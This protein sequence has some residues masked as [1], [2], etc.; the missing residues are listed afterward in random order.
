MKQVTNEELAGMINE[1]F[2][3]VKKDIRAI[4]QDMAT[5]EDLRGVQN[6]VAD[7]KQDVGTIANHIGLIED[8]FAM[9]KEQRLKLRRSRL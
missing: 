4:K 1:G 3:D 9:P 8:A 7:I 5:K 6:D 2:N